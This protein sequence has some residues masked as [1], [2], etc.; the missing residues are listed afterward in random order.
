MR[1]ANI[2]VNLILV[3]TTVVLMFQRGI[4]RKISGTF[5]F[6]EI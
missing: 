4:G 5:K 3:R 2:L 6:K 1:R